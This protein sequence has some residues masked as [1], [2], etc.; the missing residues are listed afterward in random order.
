MRA[1]DVNLRKLFEQI[2]GKVGAPSN[3][4]KTGV[5]SCIRSTALKMKAVTTSRP[6]N[7]QVT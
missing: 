5:S 7:K 3:D 2:M 4:P 1:M 6:M